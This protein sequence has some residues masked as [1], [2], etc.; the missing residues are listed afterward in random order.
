[1]F[2]VDCLWVEN[3]SGCAVGN[4]QKKKTQNTKQT[5]WGH[6]R[7]MQPLPHHLVTVQGSTKSHSRVVSSSQA[8]VSYSGALRILTLVLRPFSTP[9]R[10]RL[11]DSQILEAILAGGCCYAELSHTRKLRHT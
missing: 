3:L 1:M 10:E 6:Q 8:G 5:S 7:L 11:T 4:R 9:S 2:F